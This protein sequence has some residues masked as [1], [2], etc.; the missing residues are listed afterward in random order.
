MKLLM[1][2]GMNFLEVFLFLRDIMGNLSYKQMI[3]DVIAGIN[4]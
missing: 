2:A 4:K 3:D 1:E